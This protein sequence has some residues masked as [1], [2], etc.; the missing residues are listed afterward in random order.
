MRRPAFV[1]SGIALLCAA[2]S[3]GL[4]VATAAAFGTVMPHL[5]DLLETSPRLAML[6]FLGL[7]VA[8]AVVVAVV[9]H[10][11]LRALDGK[12]FPRSLLP[13]VESW[14][15]GAHAWLVIGGASVLARLVLLVVEPPKLEPGSLVATLTTE[16]QHVGTL[17]NVMS[18]Y[19][20]V[21]IAIAAQLFELERRTR[22]DKKG[23]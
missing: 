19:P 14:W 17:A 10:T 12:A 2:L 13:G 21:W 15:A 11:S 1:P 8:P 18:A 5:V 9:H 22:Q 6:G 4:L 7:F 3:F 16:A 23:A 20:L